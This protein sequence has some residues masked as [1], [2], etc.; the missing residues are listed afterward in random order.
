MRILNSSY[1]GKVINEGIIDGSGY[2]VLIGR[3]SQKA[4]VVRVGQKSLF[5]KDA[6]HGNFIQHPKS[7]LFNF[8]IVQMS[9]GNKI[10]LNFISKENGVFKIS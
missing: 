2:D 7:G 6:G 10:F 8:T 4:F 1:G 5:Y 3:I 9:V